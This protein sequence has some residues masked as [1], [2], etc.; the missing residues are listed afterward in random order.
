MLEKRREERRLKRTRRKKVEVYPR[1][2]FKVLGD[3]PKGSE[4]PTEKKRTRSGSL[5]GERELRKKLQSEL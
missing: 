1:L 2:S 5:G 3:G 4:N